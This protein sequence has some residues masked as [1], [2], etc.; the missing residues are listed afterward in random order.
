[1]ALVNAKIKLHWEILPKAAKKALDS[2]ADKEWLKEWRLGGGTALALQ[3]GH[4]RSVD[5]DFFKSTSFKVEN[6]IKRFS[7]NWKTE[8]IDENTLH[9][10]FCGAKV[11]FLSNLLFVPERKPISFRQLHL[12]D[13]RDLAVMK[14]IALSGRGKK[15][16]FYDLYWYARNEEKLL[17]VITRLKKQ[18]PNVAHNLHHLLKS[19]TYFG[20]AENDPEPEIFFKVRWSVIK[21]YYLTE[22]NKISKEVL[23][24]QE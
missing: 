9:G 11:S 19:L 17:D 6:V 14:I 12:Y 4:R 21:R 1:M 3:C 10:E 7:R 22:I 18:Y 2:L 15:R 24:L 16:D 5:L 13:K 8:Q 20:D 23:K